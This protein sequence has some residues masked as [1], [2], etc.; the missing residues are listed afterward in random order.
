MVVVGIVAVLCALALLIQEA[1]GAG[2]RGSF[3][4]LT[5]PECRFAVP[6]AHP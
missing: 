5:L 6:V 1:Y 4:F 2:W 3:E